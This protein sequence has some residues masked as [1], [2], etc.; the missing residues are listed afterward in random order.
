MFISEQHAKSEVH[1]KARKGPFKAGMAFANPEDVKQRF[2]YKE[3]TLVIGVLVAVIIVFTLWMKQLDSGEGTEH[4]EPVSEL[5]LLPVK[6]VL[7]KSVL[8]ILF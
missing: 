1:K 2:T 7:L 4:P 6:E 3:F 5:T 8:K